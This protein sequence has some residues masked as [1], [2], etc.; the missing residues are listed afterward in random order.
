MLR[1]GVIGCGQIAFD[2]AMPGI[3][4]ACNAELVAVSD[5]RD[6]RL[7]LVTETWG[8]SVRTFN[9]YN[10]LLACDEVDVVYLGLPN[11]VHH[12]VT[13]AAAANG[14]H[15][16]SEKPLC[17]DAREAREM[18]A[19][20]EAA[21]TRLM[22]AYMSR[23][24][25]SFVE[26]KR[27]ID[28]GHLGQI[29]MV[30][31]SFSFSAYKGY[32]LDKIGSW[33]WTGKRG[34]PLLDAGIYLAFAIRELLGCRVQRVSASMS[35][36]VATDFPAPD[37]TM[38]WFQMEDGTPGILSTCYSHNDS[39]FAI[40]GTDGKAEVYNCFAQNPGG[41]LIVNAGG[42]QLDFESQLPM[43]DHFNNYWKEI[44]H[45]SDAI[46]N[47]TPHTPSAQNALEDMMFLDAIEESAQ[48]GS[49]V[50]LT[51]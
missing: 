36:V 11:E 14:K 9:D 24:G 51:Y 35:T 17:I 40:M 45:Y 34:G 28:E 47:G 39:V 5:L 25:D 2:K 6:E 48:S 21:G 19:A 29:A 22:C 13:L 1:W 38:G 43:L 16:L 8:D 42:Y 18:I 20:A 27:V 49:I 4:K 37:T 26:T 46:L 31:A 32:T 33:R 7:A 50:E 15:V 10:D 41:H 23:F 3:N 30:S 12:P 44:E